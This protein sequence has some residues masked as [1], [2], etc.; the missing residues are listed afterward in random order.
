[1]RSLVSLIIAAV[2]TSVIVAGTSTRYPVGQPVPSS[3]YTE[4]FDPCD[5][6]YKF[7]EIRFGDPNNLRWQSAPDDWISK[8]GNNER[9]MFLHE[10]SKLKVVVAGL[11]REV[12]ALRAEVAAQGKR[13]AA[14]EEW[15]KKQGTFDP[16]AITPEDVQ[17]AM[18]KDPN[19]GKRL[20][21]LEDWQKKCPPFEYSETP[22]EKRWQWPCADPNDFALVIVKDP[23]EV[24]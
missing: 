1:M 13:L 19:E 16:N 4:P 7:L 22:T 17:V 24:K 6:A 5:P 8:F 18:P 20:L 21:A 14:L 12:L 9:T 2:L 11:A 23:N 10:T 15:R 3:V